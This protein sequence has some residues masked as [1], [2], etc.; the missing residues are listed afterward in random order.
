VPRSILRTQGAERPGEWILTPAGI[1]DLQTLE[2]RTFRQE[3]PR[4]DAMRQSRVPTLEKADHRVD[5]CKVSRQMA[6]EMRRLWRT[7][8]PSATPPPSRLDRLS[9]F[10]QSPTREQLEYEAEGQIH[11]GGREPA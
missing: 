11:L 8:F 4:N 10:A 5:R 6:Q 2:S 7:P 3:L 1:E 9:E